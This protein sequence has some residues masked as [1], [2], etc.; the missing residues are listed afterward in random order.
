MTNKLYVTVDLSTGSLQGRELLSIRTRYYLIE[1]WLLGQICN[2]HGA[3][4][5]PMIYLQ[6]GNSLKLVTAPKHAL[7]LAEMG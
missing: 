2:G 1:N 5:M 4:M 3:D 6:I 7:Q